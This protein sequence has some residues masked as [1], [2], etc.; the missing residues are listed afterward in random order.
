MEITSP[1]EGIDL[2][3]GDSVVFKLFRQGG[4][5][6]DTCAADLVV[7]SVSVEYQ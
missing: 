1:V 6:A 5:F 4:N 2:E 7:Q 3:P